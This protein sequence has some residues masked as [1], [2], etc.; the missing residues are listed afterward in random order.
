MK[1][2]VYTLLLF[3]FPIL[4]SVSVPPAMAADKSKGEVPKKLFEIE[5]GSVIQV[6]R[7]LKPRNFPV[8]QITGLQ[9]ELGGSL[10][11]LYFQPLKTYEAF[12]YEEQ[13]ETPKREVFRTSFNA[14]VVPIVATTVKSLEE[15]ERLNTDTRSFEILYVQ[16]MQSYGSKTSESEIRRLKTDG[17]LWAEQMCGVF[18]ADLE[19]TP[20]T[21]LFWDQ[22]PQASD[23]YYS[24]TFNTQD[25]ELNVTSMFGRSINLTFNNDVIVSK[26]NALEKTLYKLRANKI[27]P[28]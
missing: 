1:K 3:V 26:K 18:A 23:P 10:A 13:H 4:V 16:W 20:K 11:S 2:L 22:S 25:R 21:S 14:L 12:P 28:Y 8:A 17:Y 9:Q 24:C 15:L 5:L 19:M 6:F 27:R 7:D